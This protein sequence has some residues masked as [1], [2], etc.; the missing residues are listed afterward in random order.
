MNK[1]LTLVCILLISVCTVLTASEVRFGERPFI[2][3]YKVPDADMEQGHLRIKLDSQFSGLAYRLDYQDGK[4]KEFAI[5]ALDELNQSLQIREIIPLFVNPGLP[6]KFASRHQQWGLDLW[7][8]LRF[9]S[10]QDI[11]SLVM[12]Y[13]QLK[14]IVTWAEPE[15]KKT[16]SGSVT[17]ITAEQLSE[18]SRWTPSDPQY[19]SQWHYNNTGQTEGTVDA[20]I[21]LPE[22]W[23]IEKGHTDVIVS[24]QDQGIQTNH[25]DLAANMWINQSE[26]AGNGIDDD[27][28]GYI[29]DIYGYNFADNTGTISAGDHGCHTSGTIAAVSNNA[30]GVAGIA[31]G[32]GTGNGVRLMSCEVFS[33][34]NAG[35]ETAPVYAADNGAAVSQN[36]WGYTSA[37]VYDQPVLDA[38]DYFNINGGGTVLD[39]GI[40][41]YSAGNEESSGLW[42]PGC[43]SGAFSVAATNHEDVLSWYSNY[44]TWVEVSAPGGETNSVNTE[45]VLST[46]SGS[47]Y[48]YMQGTSMAC[49]HTSG[50]AALI[51]SNAHRNGTTLAN[52]DVANAL[53]STADNHYGVNP[54][55][56]GMLGSGRINAYSALL[57]VQPGMPSLSITSPANG[58]VIDLNSI[59]SISATASDSDGTISQVSFYIDNTWMNTDTLAPYTWNW[60]T[61]GTTGGSHTIKVTAIDNS[62]NIVERTISVT[63]LAPAD[64]GFETN[65]FGLYPWVNSSPVPWTIQSTDKYSGTYAARSGAIT[66]SGSTT[67]SL[68]LNVSAA[69]NISFYQKIS[70]E[71]GYDFLRFY[72]DGT[73]QGYWSGAGNWAQ[74]SYPVT[75]GLRTFTWTY[76]KDSSVSSGSDC[77]FLDHINLPPTGTYYAPP[78]NFAVNASHSA[79]KLT[80]TAPAAGTPTGYRIY[81]NSTLLTTLSGL[82]YTD[83]A[84]SNGTSYAY[85]LIA[86]YSGGQSEPTATLNATPNAIAPTNLT[87]VGGNGFVDLAWTAVSGFTVSG[88][89][90]YRNATYLT[91]VSGTTHH[92]TA[93]VNE[94]AYTYYVTTQ[95]TSPNGESAASNSA[96]ATPSALVPSS[97]ILGTGTATTGNNDGCPIN[98]YYK[99]LHGQSVYTAAELNAAGV[100]G[101]I[102]IT[103]IGFYIATA[104]SLALP[105]W[106]VRMK[107]TT[108]ANAASFQSADGM[109]TVYT[110]AS[111]MPTAGAFEMLTLTAPFLW[112]GTDNIV[113]DTAF[114]LVANYYSTGTIQYTTM[115]NGYLYVRS[116]TVDETNIFTGGTA[117][118]SRPNLKLSLLPVQSSQIIAVNPGSLSFEE[119]PIGRSSTLTFT[120]NNTGTALLTGT[121][122]TPAGYSV[123]EQAAPAAILSGRDITDRNQISFSLNG[124]SS[125]VYVV[126]FSPTAAIAYNGN[127]VISSNSIS[128]SLLNLPVTGSAYNPPCLTVGITE[129]ETTIG[130]D[131][132]FVDHFTI[133]NSGGRPLDYELVLE[134]VRNLN[135]M[136]GLGAST[137]LR[138]ITGSTLTQDLAGYHSGYSTD[139]N[140]SVYN[141]S[142]DSEWLKQIDITFPAGITV[143]SATVFTGGLGG[144][145]S[146]T[147]IPGSPT[148]VNWYGVD[149]SNYGLIRGGDTATATVNVTISS[150]FHSD[151]T[152]AYVLTGDVWGSEPHILNGSISIPEIVESF[153]WLSTDPLANTIAPGSNNQITVS[154]S[155]LDLDPGLYSALLN[156]NSNDP[157]NPVNTIP[158][159]M[160]VI[161][162]LEQPAVTI[163]RNGS[164]YLL[165]WSPVEYANFYQVF[166]SPEPDTGFIPLT[167]ITGT[168]Y[169]HNLVQTKGFYKVVAYNRD[170][171][172]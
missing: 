22:A 160:N 85:Y 27:T 141:A 100:F 29:D 144:D 55:Y 97:V 23:N 86:I 82:T 99:S 145:L 101:P 121:I 64:E 169:Q 91:T 155:S 124:N 41:I 83:T 164:G 138:N 154:Y 163:A 5:P 51:I 135:P 8:D 134:E 63:L 109:T 81:R 115:T 9:E 40:S 12:A 120:I 143:N 165:V 10:T 127:I 34:S 90:I 128:N 110:A 72:I 102:N 70:S 122:T 62:D 44:G 24:V 66:H 46:I 142:S 26:I 36:S 123:Q 57:S 98:I 167:V 33:S 25:P 78:Q 114:G 56:L 140:F 38:I 16:L 137:D 130:V 30:V 103:Q 129:L 43:Y 20:D 107:H 148:V 18:L 104:P 77:A 80:W 39:G 139:I 53:Q 15:Y 75:A 59:V 96:Q 153:G 170:P 132:S 76:S 84:V 14:D 65:S 151:L 106:I 125:K 28:N 117:T 113:I 146:V 89:K 49:P 1:Y 17:P 94:T 136:A 108:A 159:Q 21:D 112:N 4:L 45:G 37:G 47:S 105:N 152:L 73:E 71:S 172:L 116:D 171:R 54:G 158:V 32:S 133:A 67:L 126:T 60:D 50:V 161:A 3:I 79:V 6:N 88:Y 61:T 118:A 149:S 119:I 162:G 13:R 74:I 111:Y 2:D 147:I 92:D 58:A 95:Y 168:Q 11:R 31:G 87:A 93:V 42:Y 69:G 150:T 166:W 52:S 157:F 131:E 48:G 156:I 7:F 19:G 68:S 35:F